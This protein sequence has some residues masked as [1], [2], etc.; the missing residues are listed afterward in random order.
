MNQPISKTR[1]MREIPA[2]WNEV[3]TLAAQI[4]F[5]IIVIRVEHGIIKITEYTIKRKPGEDD[6]LTVIA[7]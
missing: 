4:K 7:I 5:G 2:E 3:M 6:N 1:V